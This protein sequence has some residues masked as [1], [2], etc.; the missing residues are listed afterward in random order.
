MTTC[1]NSLD[2]FSW[3]DLIKYTQADDIVNQL[4]N[5]LFKKKNKFFELVIYS[6]LVKKLDIEPLLSLEEFCS[7]CKLIESANPNGKKELYYK[8]DLLLGSDHLR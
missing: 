6:R 8:N 4:S 2:D 3:E 7:Q 1:T 5:E